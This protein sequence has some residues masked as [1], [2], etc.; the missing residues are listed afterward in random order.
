MSTPPPWDRVQALFEEALELEPAAREARLDR[1]A[2][3]DA[4]LA[5]EVRS[6]L[7]AHAG[8][9]GFLAGTAAHDFSRTAAPGD[10]SAPTHRRGDGRGGMGVIFRAT[11]DDDDFTTGR[12]H[13]ADLSGHPVRRHPPPLPRRAK[14]LACSTIRTS[15]GSRRRHAPDGG[16]IW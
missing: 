10:G 7:A 13:Q 5:R 1:A 3:E 12:G 15:R 9:S 16:P 11:R 2:A 8:A 14:I 6:L 4:G